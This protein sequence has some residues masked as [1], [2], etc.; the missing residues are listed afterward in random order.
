MPQSFA[1]G[2]VR[3]LRPQQWLKNSLVLAAP[4]AAGVMNQRAVATH[5]AVAFA[6]FC[7]AASGTY[8]LNDARDVESD[9]LH[10]TKRD[11]P[12]AAGVVPVP[13]AIVAGVVLLAASLAVAYEVNIDLAV[14]IGAYLAL[15]VTYTLFLK[16]VPVYD[17]VA[18]AAGFVLRAIAGATATGVPISQ[19]F[20]IVT[21][22]GALLMVV[23][24][25]EGELHV[26]GE[27]AAA[28][29]PTLGVYTDRYLVYLRSVASGVV[30]IG[31]CLWAFESAVRSGV[32]ESALV[33]YQL[34]VVPFSVAILRYGL[35]L[36]QGKGAEPEKL[37]LSDPPLLVAGA[38]WAIIYGYG[39]YLA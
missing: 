28:V 17:I 9:R 34:S 3:S 33:W 10:P 6:A 16:R 39:T 22:F 5:T 29:R 12:I 7:A 2:F 11:R 26:L 27:Q 19:W 8:L 24:K 21:S 32:H 38:C 30:L 15:T 25:R 13:V 18:V 1:L 35:L 14:T 20:F 31:Y 4:V 23:G 37:V 36:D